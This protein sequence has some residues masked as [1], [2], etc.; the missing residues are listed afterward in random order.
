M[1][2]LCN[3]ERFFPNVY[4][5]YMVNK[6]WYGGK[7]SETPESLYLYLNKRRNSWKKILTRPQTLRVQKEY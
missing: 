3:L 7:P 5:N 2:D 1:P 6:R 4:K